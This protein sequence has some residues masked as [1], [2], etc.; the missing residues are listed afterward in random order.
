MQAGFSKT[1]AKNH[2][3]Y[4]K[5]LWNI[6]IDVLSFRIICLAHSAYTTLI[7]GNK[8]FENKCRQI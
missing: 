7:N 2:I 5:N 3:S 1:L 8:V 4:I 6:F